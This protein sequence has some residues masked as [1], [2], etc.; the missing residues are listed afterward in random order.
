MYMHM[1]ADVHIYIYIPRYIY[2]HIYTYIYVHLPQSHLYML[3]STEPMR[4]HKTQCG[5][6]RDWRVALRLVCENTQC[7][8]LYS[9]GPHPRG[10]DAMSH[11]RTQPP[12][13]PMRACLCTSVAMFGRHQHVPRQRQR[14]NRPSINTMVCYL[15][16]NIHI[17]MCAY[18]HVVVGRAYMYCSGDASNT[19]HA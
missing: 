12:M 13:S 2:T 15:R 3:T 6:L 14:R 16:C 1:Y 9:L 19:A 5:L 10:R 8:A 11:V 17:S 7:I 18:T 4:K